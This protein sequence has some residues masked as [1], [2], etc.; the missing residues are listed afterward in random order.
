MDHKSTA[1]TVKH[2]NLLTDIFFKL[3]LSMEK[4]KLKREIEE[5]IETKWGN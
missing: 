2:Q 5:A 1:N 3:P 4:I